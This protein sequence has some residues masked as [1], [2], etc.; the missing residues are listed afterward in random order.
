MHET[1]F[2]GNLAGDHGGTIKN[3]T[4][5]STLDTCMFTGNSAADLG[6]RIA[7]TGMQIVSA[8]RF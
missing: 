7:N 6:R 2:D 8:W 5:I 3:A 4:G 1:N